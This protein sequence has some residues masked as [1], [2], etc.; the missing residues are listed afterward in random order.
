MTLFPKFDLLSHN[1]SCCVIIITSYVMI[2]F[3]SMTSRN[4]RNGPPHVKPTWNQHYSP[5]IIHNNV[6]TMF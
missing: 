1:V 2:I 4:G 3:H 6:L 5:Q